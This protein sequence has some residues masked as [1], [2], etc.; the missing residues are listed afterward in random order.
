MIARF[1][2]PGP[3]QGKGRPRFT[4]TGHAFTPAKTAEYERQIRQAYT[5]QC[6]QTFPEDAALRVKIV[7]WFSVPASDSKARRDMKL[8]HKMLPI[9][10]P[11]WDNI[12]K[13]I[14]DA[15]NGLAYR[16]D[17]QIVDGRVIKVYGEQPKVTVIIEVIEADNTEPQHDIPTNTEKPRRAACKRSHGASQ[18]E[19]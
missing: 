3:P 6:G 17:S 1:T 7:A 12:G 8:K 19:D 14:C 2:V 13:V 16:D 10:K 18:E 4:R 9:K 5:R 11:D 15:L